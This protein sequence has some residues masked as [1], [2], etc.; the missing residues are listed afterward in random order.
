MAKTELFARQQSGGAFVFTDESKTT[1]D[2]FFVHSG[3]GTDSTSYGR[4]P[5]APCATLDYAV[6]LCT[7]SKG[8]RIYVMPGH[9]ETITGAAGVNLDVAGVKVVGLGQ[10]RN[11]PTF[12]FTT[13]NG[14]SFDIGAANCHVEGLVF[15][16]G[17]DG[18]TAVVNVTA[19][20]VTIKGCEFM[21]ADASTQAAVGI[22]ASAAADRLTVD[23]CHLHGTADAGVTSAISI[24]A[25]DDTVIKNCIITGAHSTSGSIANSAAAINVVVQ[26]NVIIN[27]TADG[28]NKAV[29]FHGS[30]TGLI[31]DN[32]VAIID[33]TSP[34]PFTAAAGYVSNN[35]IVGA[36]GVAASTLV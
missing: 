2:I 13:A 20:D 27:N 3:T 6:S 23:G 35:Y 22:L 8:D 26:G 16:N 24:G 28:N 25:C 21:L 15:I 19:A 1:G 34:A 30:T 11:R 32:R 33:S 5:D 29:V 12:T 7:A 18:Q 4:N 9:A 14:A 31:V 17:K 10:G 36:V